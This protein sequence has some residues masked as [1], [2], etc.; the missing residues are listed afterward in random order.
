MPRS[1]LRPIESES[2]GVVPGCWYFFKSS[3][4]AYYLHSIF[5]TV[6]INSDGKIMMWNYVY[7]CNRFELKKEKL[8]YTIV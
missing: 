2:L 1:R 7:S 5:S 3:S 6:K 4:Q 8:N